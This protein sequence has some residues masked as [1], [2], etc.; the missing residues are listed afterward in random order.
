MLNKINLKTIFLIIVIIAAVTA[1]YF[2]NKHQ[3][4]KNYAWLD[5]NKVYNE[6]TMK[7]DLEKQYTVVESQRKKILDSLELDLKLLA[8]RFASLNDKDKDEKAIEFQQKKQ[9]YLLRKQEFD[10]DNEQLKTD[11]NQQVLKQI[12][13]YTKEYAIKKEYAIVLG[14]EGSGTLMYANES[15][16]I[17]KDVLKFINNRYKGTE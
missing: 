15:I 17:T 8:S 16:N 11:Y 2:I 14:A 5:L 1:N 4:E 6:F 3:F 12:N 13:Q 7:K 10:E 9:Q